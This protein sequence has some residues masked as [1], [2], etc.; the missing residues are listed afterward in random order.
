MLNK[1]PSEDAELFR[2]DFEIVGSDKPIEFSTEAVSYTHLPL[3]TSD[4][5]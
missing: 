5:V 1:V 3:P 2:K 4:L